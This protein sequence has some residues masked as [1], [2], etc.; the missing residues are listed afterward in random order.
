MGALWC[1]PVHWYVYLPEGYVKAE[2]LQDASSF[3][4]VSFMVQYFPDLFPFFVTIEWPQVLVWSDIFVL[5]SVKTFQKKNPKMFQTNLSHSIPQ[6]F[7]RMCLLGIHIKL[8]WLLVGHF[9]HFAKQFHMFTTYSGKKPFSVCECRVRDKENVH[10]RSLLLLFSTKIHLHG[11]WRWFRL[12]RDH[13]C[14]KHR[15]NVPTLG[16]TISS[17]VSVAHF[18]CAFMIKGKSN[19]NIQTIEDNLFFFS[20]GTNCPVFQAQVWSFSSV[21]GG[22]CGSGRKLLQESRLGAHCLVLYYRPDLQIRAVQHSCLC[23]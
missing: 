7:C 5:F 2:N 16:L 13:Q 14:H 8:V 20:K 12:H 9:P 22:H 19:I 21:P 11:D 10:W 6:T 15:Q 17:H 23:G 3:G 1:S 18:H 4:C